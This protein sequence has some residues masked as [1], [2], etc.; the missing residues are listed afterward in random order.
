MFCELYNISLCLYEYIEVLSHH[1]FF[2]YN[3]FC[4][5]KS[6]ATTFI[7]PTTTSSCTCVTS[8][9]TSCNDPSVDLSALHLQYSMT[10]SSSSFPVQYGTSFPVQCVLG[11]Y[12]ASTISN[13]TCGI[14]GNWIYPNCN[15]MA[16]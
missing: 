6:T 3:T 14:N 4:S 13:I 9:T 16:N 10:P 11:Y 1:R 5:M 15:R 12:L 8:S 7:I 2:I